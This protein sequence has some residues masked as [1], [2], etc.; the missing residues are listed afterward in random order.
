MGVIEAED[1]VLAPLELVFEAENR[2]RIN[3]ELALLRT[4]L[5]ANGEYSSH[6]PRGCADKKSAG[7]VR[8]SGLRCVPQLPEEAGRSVGFKDR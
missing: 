8:P 2:Q 1:L 5:I 7:F 6:P 3:R 4:A